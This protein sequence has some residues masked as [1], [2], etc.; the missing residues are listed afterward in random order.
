L[1][2]VIAIVALTFGYYWSGDRAGVSDFQLSFLLSGGFF[3]GLD[4]DA[5]KFV[6]CSA[7]RNF[8]VKAMTKKGFDGRIL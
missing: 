4:T 1:L 3:G 6:G 5:N 2:F 8:L 7:I